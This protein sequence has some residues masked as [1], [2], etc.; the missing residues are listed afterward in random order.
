SIRHGVTRVRTHTDV[1]AVTGMRAI[2]GVLAAARDRRH[3][4]DVEVVAFAT[5]AADPALPQTRAL[6]A[7]AVARGATVIGSVPALSAD[8]AAALA[9][10]MQLAS[11]LGLA[12][13]LHLDEHLEAGRMLV[14][15]AIE[16]TRALDL[17]GRV[18]LSHACTLSCLDLAALERVLEDMADLRI[19]LVAL[20]ELN[21][22]LQDRGTR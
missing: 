6:L 21:L 11:E 14:A 12:V 22:Y 18:T 8:P 15:K 4:I 10:T 5:A 2:D 9:A 1:D 3:A 7:Q 19:E 17:R 13:D 16:I 20:P